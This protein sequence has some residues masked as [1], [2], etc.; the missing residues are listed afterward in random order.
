MPRRCRYERPETTPADDA[1]SRRQ[2]LFT[3]IRRPLV[4]CPTA[5]GE[6]PHPLA[7]RS[8]WASQYQSDFVGKAV[9]FARIAAPAGS[10]HIVPGV[11]SAATAR[12]DVIDALRR[13]PAVLTA[14]AVASEH[15]PPVHGH[16]PV[17]GYSHVA[18]QA[19][20]RRLRDRNPLRP[21]HPVGGVHQNGFGIENQQKGSPRRDNAQGLEG[22][23]QDQR[24]TRLL[25][26]AIAGQHHIEAT[27]PR[28]R[29]LAAPSPHIPAP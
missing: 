22:G 28:S 11:Q 21:K 10:H 3:Q 27:P 2:R 29:S 13:G 18:C 19:H 15:R 26:S 17:M 4:P 1:A 9:L 6:E 20:N 7:R 8:R 16:R 12:H 23:V 5:Q 25:R 24:P 14:M